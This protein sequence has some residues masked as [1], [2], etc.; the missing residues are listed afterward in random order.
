MT[1]SVAAAVSGDGKRSIEITMQ[2][3]QPGALG[4]LHPTA[5]ACS[6]VRQHPMLSHKNVSS[7]ASTVH[8]SRVMQ[9]DAGGLWPTFTVI[10]S[11]GTDVS[12]AATRTNAKQPLACTHTLL[13]LC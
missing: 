3:Q 4:A 10:S 9:Q 5:G 12:Q 8:S 11:N 2:S 13:H 1:I 6:P 7:G